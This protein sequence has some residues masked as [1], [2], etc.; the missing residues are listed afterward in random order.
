MAISG[1]LMGQPLFVYAEIQP[2]VNTYF[3]LG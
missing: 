1:E 3:F 2:A